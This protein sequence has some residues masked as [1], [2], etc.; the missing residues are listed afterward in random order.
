MIA[1]SSLIIED[2]DPAEAIATFNTEAKVVRNLELTASHVRY[3]MLKDLSYVKMLKEL[4]STTNVRLTAIHAPLELFNVSHELNAVRRAESLFKLASQL[5]V[6]LLTFHVFQISPS[7]EMSTEGMLKVT[8]DLNKGVFKELDFMAHN[9]FKVFVENSF[10]RTY[11]F[12]PMDL[13]EIVEGLE[14]VEVCFDV[15]HA[16]ANG[17]DLALFHEVIEDYVGMYHVHDNDGMH[18]LHLLPL[19]GNV[20]WDSIVSV[21]NKDKPIILEISG[22][23]RNK[24]LIKLTEIVAKV[25]GLA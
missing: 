22:S 1:I 7:T 19:M 24:G 13:L 14:N 21:I 4:I 6:Y 15:G 9:T 23:S 12:L 17:L 11:G 3:L 2:L 18:D 10:Q 8:K 16:H 20:K 25:I 5:E